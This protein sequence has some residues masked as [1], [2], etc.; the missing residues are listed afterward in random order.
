MA[1][2]YENPWEWFEEQVRENISEGFYRPKRNWTISMLLQFMKENISNDDIQ[3]F[4]QSEMDED[5]YFE[6]LQ[7]NFEEL[8]ED[9]EE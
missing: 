9:L 4:F 2:K 3:L 6:E 8:E 5:G 1:Y 7:E